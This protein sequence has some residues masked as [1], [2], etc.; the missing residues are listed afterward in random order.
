MFPWL[1]PK[2]HSSDLHAPLSQHWSAASS[3]SQHISKSVSLYPLKLIRRKA[4]CYKFLLPSLS[5]HVN[6]CEAIRI[7]TG[8]L[9]WLCF[10]GDECINSQ[11]AEIFLLVVLV[12]KTIHPPIKIH[13]KRSYIWS[14]TLPINSGFL[15]GNKRLGFI[16]TSHI[17]G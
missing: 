11:S 13:L 16:P 15:P 17:K 1:P 8:A 14:P 2:T 7:K 6:L 3:H 5:C 12:A 10:D 9:P 4:L